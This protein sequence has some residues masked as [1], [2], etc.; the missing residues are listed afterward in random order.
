VA[1]LALQRA[2]LADLE[3]S[4]QKQLKGKNAIY[5]DPDSVGPLINDWEKLKADLQ[6]EHSD[7]LEHVE[8]HKKAE[9]SRTTDFDGRGYFTRGQ[10][11]DALDDVKRCTGLLPAVPELKS[12]GPSPPR[13][14]WSI[15]RL[16]WTIVLGLWTVALGYSNHT[17]EEQRVDLERQKQLGDKIAKV[18]EYRSLY[19]AKIGNLFEIWD[20]I[21]R[22]RSLPGTEDARASLRRKAWVIQQEMVELTITLGRLEGRSPAKIIEELGV[23]HPDS[24][25]SPDQR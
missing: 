4:F 20:Q 7:R 25:F 6:S 14:F 3:H 12:V 5:F 9:A 8:F 10:I 19:L 24:L 11:A 23:S 16:G 15:G 22:M 1:D 18:Q 17:L 2:R 13:R 21:N